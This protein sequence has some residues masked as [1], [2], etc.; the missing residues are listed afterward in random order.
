MKRGYVNRS[1]D[2]YAELLVLYATACI[3]VAFM[4]AVIAH[5]V[6]YV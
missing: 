1:K 6:I 3:S 2:R 4:V 5:W